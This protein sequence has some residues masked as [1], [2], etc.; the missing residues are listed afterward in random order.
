M[1]TYTYKEYEMW[2]CG[3]L[4]VIS[5]TV[6]IYHRNEWKDPMG[7]VSIAQLIKEG[8]DSVLIRDIVT[9]EDH[10]CSFDTVV[11]AFPD[12]DLDNCAFCGGSGLIAKEGYKFDPQAVYE[13]KRR[14]NLLPPSA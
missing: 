4:A 3:A 10:E 2:H 11:K 7:Y 13:F 9:Q 5:L 12:L 8:V 1:L 6:D 14:E